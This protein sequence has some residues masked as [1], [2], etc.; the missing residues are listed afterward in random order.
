[1]RKQPQKRPGGKKPPPPPAPPARENICRIE[2]FKCSVIGI[3]GKTE[4]FMEN[5][6]Q[7]IYICDMCGKEDPCILKCE[8]VYEDEPPINCPFSKQKVCQW[9]E[10]K[11]LPECAECGDTGMV[12]VKTGVV[13]GP[14]EE[15]VQEPCSCKDGEG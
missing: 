12:K 5:E 13:D 1:M 7:T 6:N 10:K 2:K 11:K 8:N 14:Y 15:V 4:E 9:E 3:P